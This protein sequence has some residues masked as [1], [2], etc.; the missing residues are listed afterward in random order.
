MRRFSSGPSTYSSVGAFEV[1]FGN[2]LQLQNVYGPAQVTKELGHF[3][4]LFIWHGYPQPVYGRNRKVIL[5]WCC[6]S[7]TWSSMA[8]FTLFT[9]AWGKHTKENWVTLDLERFTGR[10]GTQRV[11]E[12]LLLSREVQNG[13]PCFLNPSQRSLNAA[14]S[15]RSPRLRH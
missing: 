2:T 10:L 9:T 6:K 7:G 11:R 14:G 4:Y 8:R 12:A 5:I 1:L 3:F 15:R 13:P